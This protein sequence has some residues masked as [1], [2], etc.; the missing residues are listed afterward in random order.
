[1]RWPS[2][3]AVG[4]IARTGVQM[5]WLHFVS[6]KSAKALANG[7][8][9]RAPTVGS[10]RPSTSPCA[11]S[12]YACGSTTSIISFHIQLGE[13][14]C[15]QDVLPATGTAFARPPSMQTAHVY[16]SSCSDSTRS[17][18]AVPQW[19]EHN[20]ATFAMPA[21]GFLC[22]PALAGERRLPMCFASACGSGCGSRVLAPCRHPSFITY[23]S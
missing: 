7:S 9:R 4:S 1:M 22:L 6:C 19:M 21:C 18:Y 14:C 8:F 23:A 11:C 3:A 20:M 2:D 10:V 17:P 12:C 5:T 16:G 15:L 13:S